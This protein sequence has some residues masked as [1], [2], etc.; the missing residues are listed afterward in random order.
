[1]ACPV[2]GSHQVRRSRVW[3]HDSR[4]NTDAFNCH[5][6]R[7]TATPLRPRRAPATLA[8]SFRHRHSTL[9]PPS[10]HSQIL[11]KPMKCPFLHGEAT[12]PAETSVVANFG[13]CHLDPKE[14][15]EDCLLFRPG[16][17]LGLV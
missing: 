1:M 3:I 8:P 2:A 6:L 7:A 4:A 5:S 13:S 17:R 9:P 14:W 12:L 16:R 11:S 15:G 10:L